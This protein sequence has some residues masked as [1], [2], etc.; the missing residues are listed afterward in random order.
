MGSSTTNRALTK[1][2]KSQRSEPKQIKVKVTREDIQKATKSRNRRMPHLTCPIAQ[3]LKRTGHSRVECY[4]EEIRCDNKKF[5][6]TEEVDNFQFN[7][8]FGKRVKPATF[9]LTGKK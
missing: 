2:G 9:I 7:Y 8:V 4:F 3:A 1:S 6:T 5:A